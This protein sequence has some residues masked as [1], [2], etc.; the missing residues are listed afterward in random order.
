MNSLAFDF[1]YILKRTID[2]IELNGVV[3]TLTAI[4]CSSSTTFGAFFLFPRK[5][6]LPRLRRCLAPFQTRAPSSGATTTISTT[7]RWRNATMCEPNWPG[8]W[9]G[10]LCRAEARNSPAATTTST[11]AKHWWPDFLC[12]SVNRS[13]PFSVAPEARNHGEFAFRQ[14]L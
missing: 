3:A 1:V 13:A 12:R 8:S 2:R 10:L 5:P 14:L 11:S 9:T 6:P 7:A 4:P